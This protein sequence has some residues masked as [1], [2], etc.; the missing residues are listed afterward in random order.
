M[1]YKICATHTCGEDL[2]YEAVGT[3]KDQESARKSISDLRELAKQEDHE[4]TYRYDPDGLYIGFEEEWTDEQGRKNK[5]AAYAT[6][7]KE[8]GEK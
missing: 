5:Y 2:V 6:P 1:K 8:E 3:K 7:I 4:F